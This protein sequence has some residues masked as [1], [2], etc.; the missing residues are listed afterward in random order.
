MTPPPIRSASLAPDVLRLLEFIKS[1]GRPPLETLPHAEARDAYRRSRRALQADPEPVA[2]VRPLT[3]EAQRPI[4]AR[5]Y[6]PLADPA[7][8][9][10]ALIY[11]HG[12]GWVVGDLD[13]H[14][15]PCRWLANAGRCAVV[16]VDYRLAPEHKF[17]AAVD[18]AIAAASWIAAHGDAL[19]IDRDRLAIGGDSAGG[20]LAAVTTLHARDSGGPAFR[21]QLLI[22]P[23]VDFAGDYPSYHAHTRDLPLTTGAMIWFRDHYLRGADDYADWRAS[24]LRAPR[25]GGL[26]PA[27]VLTA[28]FD[29]LY[30]EGAAYARAL[31]EAD[32][33]VTHRHLADQLHG[34]VTMGR[35]IA[36]AETETK[37]AARMMGEAL[38]AAAAD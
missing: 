13:T 6:R 16:S 34:F 9:L 21:Y 12:G 5:L 11:F 19:A 24:P 2:D 33:S 1:A 30:G 32:V 7:E 15:G 29:P 38:R 14:D 37:L 25:L 10:P 20:N 26:P 27:Y 35:F 22:Y 28:G 36:A 17:P 23:A 18:D 8:R 4:P 31:A 3:I